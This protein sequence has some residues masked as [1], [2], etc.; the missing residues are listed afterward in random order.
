MHNKHKN[1]YVQESFSISVSHPIFCLF[2]AQTG[3]TIGIQI[4]IFG[5]NSKIVSLCVRFPVGNRYVLSGIII[6]PLGSL[7]TLTINELGKQK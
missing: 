3:S 5:Q 2:L 4:G 1:K 7:N 6:K